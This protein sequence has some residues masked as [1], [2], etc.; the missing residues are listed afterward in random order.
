[1]NNVTS[2]LIIDDDEDDVFLIQD[3]L[4]SLTNEDC[5]FISCSKKEEAIQYLKER[6][7]DI[8]ILDYRL[9]GYKG[10]DI[11][12]AVE[13]AQLATPII[14]LTGQEDKEVA[15][16]AIKLGAQDF[17]PKSSID[18]DVFEKS[19]LY[20][21][22]RKE[23]EFAKLVSQVKESEN[24]AKDKFI[25]HLSHELRT[26]LTSIL[27]YTS[28]LLEKEEAAPLKQELS[29]ISNNGKHLL[30]LLNDVLDLS[31]IAAGKFELKTQESDL[32]QV[33]AE[34]NSLLC[35]A[36]LD[37]GLSLEFKSKSKIPRIITIDE[38]RFKQV[39]V[40]LIG[41]AIKFT[42]YGSVQICIEFIMGSSNESPALKFVIED[43]GIGMDA[44]Q[45]KT[46]FSPFQQVED[47][48]NRKAGG[49]GLGLSISAEIIKQMGGEVHVTSTPGEG[50]VFT[51]TYPCVY[52]PQ[53]LTLFDFTFEAEQLRT[54]NAPQL[55]S[56]VLVVD[57]LF[58]IR[59]LAGYFVE[60][61][62]ATVCFAK[63]GEEALTKVTEALATNQPF[64]LV[65]M[66]LH[67][68]VMTGETAMRLI[69]PLAPNLPVIA[70]TAAISK[71]LFDEIS[72][73]GF[74]DLIAKPIDKLNLW[75]KLQKYLLPQVTQKNARIDKPE[76]MPTVHLVEDDQDSADIMS[77]MIGSIGYSVIHSATAAEAIH[78]AE[79]STIAFHLVDLGLPDMPGETLL[80]HLFEKQIYGEVY[81]V[82]GSHPSQDLL[83]QYPIKQHLLKPINKD[84]LLQIL[85]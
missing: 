74:A 45:I 44:A 60:Q 24:I 49:A 76:A 26:P 3:R 36:A 55:S 78:N 28:L 30:N 63:H 7:F 25:A 12:E 31:K 84:M 6:T 21:I 62:G 1:V 56:K 68:P 38:L 81:I 32:Q 34:I 59:Q 43:T 54:T 42:D 22:S 47:V 85:A 72:S 40:N 8:C 37:K 10:L 5:D 66:D 13:D 65:L 46:I 27:G 53:E 39:M 67:M 52:K 83:T 18:E 23:L 2:V 51:L 73:L 16:E 15:K 11:L 17:V 35:V 20:A 77:L 50:S 33:L 61:T 48:A 69:K 75:N 19:L 71:G 58:E 64:D 70:M 14:M 79:D 82:S 29:I 9:A 4:S 57:D 80:K 41:N